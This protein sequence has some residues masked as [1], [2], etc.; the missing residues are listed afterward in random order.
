MRKIDQFFFS[1]RTNNGLRNRWPILIDYGE[2]GGVA[3]TVFI[4]HRL[5]KGSFVGKSQ[6]TGS[7]DRGLIETVAFPFISPVAQLENILHQHIVSFGGDSGALNCRRQHHAADFKTTVFRHHP[8][9]RHRPKRTHRS[10][11]NDGIV[12]FAISVGNGGCPVGIVVFGRKW[13]GRYI[14]PVTVI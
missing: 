14:R 12:T 6:S 1:K 2:P 4:D 7:P 11:I 8:H 9:Q 13:S 10:P 5:T 3:A